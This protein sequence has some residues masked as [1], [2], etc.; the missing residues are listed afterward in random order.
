MRD[1][2]LFLTSIQQLLE[3]FLDEAINPKEFVD[4]YDDLMADD[5]P[6]TLDQ[7]GDIYRL[8]DTYQTEFALYVD[9][10]VMRNEY[11]GYYGAYELQQKA[12]V[13]LE[14]ICQLQKHDSTS[15]GKRG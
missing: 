3:K 2:L 11:N 14:K 10:P 5:L 7:S 4:G 1:V 6:D 13:L 9:D 12:R 15:D 8:L